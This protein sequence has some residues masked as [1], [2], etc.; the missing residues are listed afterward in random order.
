[1]PVSVGEGSRLGSKLHRNRNPTGGRGRALSPGIITIPAPSQATR[2]DLEIRTRSS[3]FLRL[4]VCRQRRELILH[5]HLPREPAAAAL[6]AEVWGTNERGERMVGER[7]LEPPTPWF[8]TRWNPKSKCFIWYRLGTK[9]PDFLSPSN[10]PKLYRDRR[11]DDCRPS[12]A[13]LWCHTPRGVGLR[14]TQ[15][16]PS[17]SQTTRGRRC[18]AHL[19]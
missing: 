7:G 17:R 13:K 10:V 5:P 14:S 18:A 3:V 4:P 9:E 8:R 16:Q 19:L 6:E 2:P 1:M 11:S 12:I 15:E